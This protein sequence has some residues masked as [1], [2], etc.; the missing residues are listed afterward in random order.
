MDG[1]I[2]LLRRIELAKMEHQGIV[3]D[4]SPKGFDEGVASFGSIFVDADDQRTL[5]LYYAG[6]QSDRMIQSAIGLA[7]TKDGLRFE[8]VA[9]EP[10]FAPSYGSFCHAQTVTPIVTKIRNRFYMILAGK[11][12]LESARRIGIA[13]ADDPKGPWNLIEEL[14]KPS[15]FWEGNGVDNGPSIAKLDNET[16]L[17]Y[18]S[19]ITSTKSYDIGA[20]IRRYPVRRIGLL[21]VRIRG[22]SSSQIEAMRYSG[23]PLKHLNG[24]KGSWN[25]SVFCPGYIKIND[26][27]YLFPTGSTYSV[28]F[29]YKQY[30]GT[31]TSNSPYFKKETCRTAKLID[32]PME[33]TKI[34]PNI[35]GEIAMDTASPYLDAEKRKLFLYY[36]VADRAD[37]IWKIALTTFDVPAD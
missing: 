7:V 18:Y 19:S 23:N 33:K 35:K 10:V 31:V 2:S 20:I 6:A 4:V 29:P 8:K 3:L 9:H 26:T 36:S 32:G 15:Q 16:I 30:I 17:L 37:G 34:M 12:S 14:I 21:K 28:G 22:T 25:E 24:P 13:Y 1:R 27:D 5:Y 11:P